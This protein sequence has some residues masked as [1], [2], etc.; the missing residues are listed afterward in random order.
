[1]KLDIYTRVSQVGGREGESFGSPDEQE[2]ICRAYADSQ[3]WD[4]DEVITE[5]DV[6]GAT[7]VDQ[8]GLG[9]LVAR[10]EAGESNG[11]LVRH[12]DRFG[13]SVVEGALAYKRIAAVGARLVAVADGLDSSRDGSKL[14]FTMLLAFAEQT[15]DRNRA[16]YISGKE[17]AVAR[18]VYA[19]VAPFGYDRDADGRL[20]PNDD[21]E[22]VRLIFK[23]RAEGVGFSEIARRVGGALTRSGVRRVV[24]NTAYLGEQRIPNPNRPGEPKVIKDSH[25]PLVTRAEFEAANAVKGHAP[26]RRG[27]AERT[28]L[29]GVI[30]CGLCGRNMHVLAY[31]SPATG[32][33]R[34]LTYACTGCG[35]SS[36]V[37]H[38]ADPAVDF[39]L[40]TAIM[41]RHPA[42]A[43]VIEGDNRYADALAEVEQAQQA[44]AEYR[45]NIEMQQ[46]L[47][48][49]DFAEGLR[50]RKEAVEVARRALRQVPRPEPTSNR[51]LTL[52]EFTRDDIA[53]FRRRVIAE[54]R[55]YP[56]SHEHRL[57]LRWH[58]T[59]EELP[60]PF[61]KPTPLAELTV[62]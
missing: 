13:R 40:D 20:Q 21:A 35:R 11:I 38:K 58:G 41:Q 51:A 59:E 48:M 44:L 3:S 36:L 16:A 60:V 56:R 1:V 17:R 15:Y 22:T 43:A 54:V 31:G 53:A 28:M 34:S 50:V 25:R 49:R 26:I 57:T 45:D 29:K 42:V 19:A 37:V 6:S 27:L 2:A 10:C 62:A 30:K 12:L 23:L 61:V 8:R 52:E 55:V 14:Q 33:K 18:G 7:P 46:V 39:M 4:V 9:Y 47:G 5:L 24:M 32:K